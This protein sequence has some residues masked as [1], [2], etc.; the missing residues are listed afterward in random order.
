MAFAGGDPSRLRAA[1][2]SLSTLSEDLTG[3]ALTATGQGREA[4]SAAGDAQVAQLA[5]TALA[6]VGGALMA[7]AALVSGL[8]EGS[9][10]ASDQLLTATGVP[11]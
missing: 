10:T 1:S 7:T 4:A 2:R 11:R 3:D 5:E 8:S 6:A 9:T